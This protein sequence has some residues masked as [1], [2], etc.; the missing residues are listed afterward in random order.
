M[1]ARA[2]R[3]DEGGAGW[4]DYHLDDEGRATLRHALVAMAQL[5][6]AGG[7]A[8]ILAVGMPL[9]ATRGRRGR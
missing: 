1:V 2:G 8:E 4:I 9:A 3:A 7:A 6:R 5:A